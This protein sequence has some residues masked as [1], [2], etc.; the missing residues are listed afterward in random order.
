M[1]QDMYLTG[2]V[3]VNQFICTLLP[4]SITKNW[5]LVSPVCAI[6]LLLLLSS[7]LSTWKTFL[8]D[9]LPLFYT[10]CSC[11]TLCK[12]IMSTFLSVWLLSLGVCSPLR[13]NLPFNVS[14]RLSPGNKGR[15]EEGRGKRRR[16]G[17]LRQRNAGGLQEEGGLSKHCAVHS[18]LIQTS[19]HS[20]S[21]CPYVSHIYTLTKTGVANCVQIIV[22]SHSPI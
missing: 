12:S 17:G 4:S 14:S 20:A 1:I 21:T 3:K 8:S 18:E 5:A 7:L 13:A 19:F 22:R 9:T 15:G 6:L 10:E 11:A 16:R 2:A